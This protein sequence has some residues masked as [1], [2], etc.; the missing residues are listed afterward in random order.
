MIP[1]DLILTNATVVTMDSEF[2]AFAPGAVA[3]R[4][5][6][7][8]AVGPA[9]A[10]TADFEA[11]QI[12]DC[13]GLTIMPGLVNAHT[14]VPMTLLR[15]LADDLRLDVWLIG[16]MMPVEREFVSPEFVRLGT[17]LGCA[18]MIQSGI[19]SFADMYYYEDSVAEAAA[20][21]GMRA[22]AGQ[23]I[24]KF[25]S[26]DAS[27]YEE[28]L[29][30]CRTFIEKWRGHPLIVPAIAPHAPYTTTAEI[31]QTCAEIAT[32]YDVPLHI[33]ISE[34]AQEV[35][36]W[37]EEYGMPVVPWVKKQGLFDAKVIA[38]HCVHI[39][40]GEMH[41]LR[42]NRAGVAH[43]PT[44]NLKLASGIAPVGRMLE[45]GLN[46][47]IGTD[48]PASNNDLDMFE[49]TRLA[50]ILAKVATDDP[51]TLPARDAL[52]MATRIG[53]QALHIGDITGSLEVGKRADLAILDL[54]TLHSRPSFSHDPNAIYSQI[55]Y[56][57]KSTDVR[58]VICN[59]QW[60]M[61][62]RE[63]LT[64]SPGELLG[65][66]ERM[67]K[68]IDTFLVARED[69][70]VQKLLAIGELQ[71][72]ESF[73][74]QVKAH[75]DDPARVQTLLEWDAIDVVGRSHYRQYDTYFEFG[76]PDFYRLRYREDDFIDPKGNV[77]S[78]RARL[79]LTE[80]GKEHE[81]PRAIILSR[82][83]YISPATRPL[84]FYREY[85]QAE[86][87]RLI[88]K[89]RRRWHID[90]KDLR[91]YVN[92]DKFIDPPQDGYFLEI[93]SR[94]WSRMDAERKAAAIAEMLDTLDIGAD[95]LIR[96]EYIT[97]A[98][99]APPEEAI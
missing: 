10:V 8:A 95:A 56:S 78:V 46:V 91:F 2:S 94:T 43:N 25:P 26:P 1:V 3:I 85:V 89:E 38:A 84:R 79:T 69:D 31:L 24:L 13:T 17:L 32:E 72:E 55:I 53:A 39:D 61:C 47:G 22:I 41:T 90:Y 52:A 4:G 35:L 96:D 87:E 5:D 27:S 70:I 86:N 49:E 50:A 71:Q 19:T 66:A 40:E 81:F 15:G 45:L 75:L 57:A 63:L 37:R 92:L 51:T 7:I 62:D 44:S 80:G 11:A 16:Y 88:V 28:A 93:K 67:A 83:R 58:H 23:T 21:A 33:H 65:R 77:T 6:S 97:Y 76:A 34:T 36:E 48:G 18:E 20:E 82:S 29:A 60:L 64:V 99:T 12:V 68:E 42:N 59:G 98:R 14:H 73:E 9:D 30:A 54:Q 74:V